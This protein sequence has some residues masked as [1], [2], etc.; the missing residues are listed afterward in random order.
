MS[1]ENLSTVASP[2]VLTIVAIMSSVGL[3]TGFF[4]RH[5]DSV[6]KAIARDR[7]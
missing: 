3:V 6:L 2:M 5:L 4:L 1:A 7:Y